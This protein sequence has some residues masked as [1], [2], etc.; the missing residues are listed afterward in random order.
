M[1]LVKY[2]QRIVQEVQQATDIVDQISQVVALKRAGRNFKGLCPFHEEK[3]PSFMVSPEKQ[4]FHCFGCGVGGDVVS[5]LMKYEN[6]SFVEALKALAERANI[7][8]PEMNAKEAEAVS[9][10]EKIYKIYRLAS[11]Y[12]HSRFNETGAGQEA[13]NY[14][15]NRGYD[16]VFAEEFKVGWAPSEWQ[17]LYNFLKKKGAPENLILKSALVTRSTHGKLYDVFRG[18]ILFPIQ[19]LQGKV[20]GFGGRLLA[21]SPNSPKYLNSPENPVFK[22][23]RE[24]FGLQLAKKFIDRDKPQILVVEGYMDFFRLY[25]SGFKA[26]V[27]TLGTALTNEHVKLLKRFAEEA[28]VIYDGDQAGQNAALRGIEVFLE[29]GM[30]LKLIAMPDGLDPDDFISKNG[31]PAFLNLIKNAE[32]FFDYKFRL[33]KAKHNLN[34]SLGL[35]KVT[36]EFVELFAKI[37]NPIL[38][39]H[40]VRKLAMELRLDEESI[41]GE[42]QKITQKNE[43]YRKSG[44][45]SKAK[46]IK[47]PVRNLDREEVY[48]LGAIMEDVNLLDRARQELTPNDFSQISTQNFYRELL[49]REDQLH[50]SP[51]NPLS[52]ASDE[53]LKSELA[54]LLALD[55]T[56]E[57]RTQTFADCLKRIK[58]KNVKKQLDALEEAIR[59]AEKRGNQAEVGE[60]MRQ[61]QSLQAKSKGL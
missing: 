53:K 48:L 35:I 4:I 41:R 47:E 36:N 40:Y 8:L 20:V 1:A 14:L 10:T 12:Y 23:R 22:K 33:S 3:T 27:A 39:S 50:D 44:E 43:R 32:D 45:P 9:E 2:D 60:Y 37:K 26:S 58:K 38:R 19:N 5:F 16:E 29:E 30:N 6:Y 49:D 7:R 28:I 15:K 61:Y 31:E 52:L 59:G 11:Q 42:I 25:T 56:A 17:G 54:S 18:R 46:K 34:D 21:D 57:K 13:R 51:Q 24:L 55:W